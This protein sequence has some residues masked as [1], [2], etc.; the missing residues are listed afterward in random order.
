M[1]ETDTATIAHSDIEQVQSDAVSGRLRRFSLEQRLFAAPAQRLTGAFARGVL[2]AAEPDK[3]VAARLGPP[4]VIGVGA[5]REVEN[6]Y[7]SVYGS[8]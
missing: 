8:R 4:V 1:T 6:R 3:I 7:L 2:S 5:Y